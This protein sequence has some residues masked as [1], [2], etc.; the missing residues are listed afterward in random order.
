MQTKDTSPIHDLLSGPVPSL[1]IK[2]VRLVDAMLSK[3]EGARF[4]IVLP[5]GSEWTHN[6][7]EAPP[8]KESSRKAYSHVHA[9]GQ[10]AALYLPHI[11]T[12]E[13]GDLTVFATTADIP[14]ESLRSAAAGWAS[15]AWGPGCHESSI[16]KATSMIEFMRT[17]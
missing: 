12:L 6:L 3:L 15:K 1:V 10:L 4:K 17:G 13:I 2:Q 11:G 9:K 16:N 5:D 14:I 7:E 8:P